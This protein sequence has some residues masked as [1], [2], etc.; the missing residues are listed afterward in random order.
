MHTTAQAS[1]IAKAIKMRDNW[2]GCSKEGI[3][4]GSRP[5][6]EGSS[7]VLST[8]R[9]KNP[10]KEALLQKRGFC[11]RRRLF[12]EKKTSCFKLKKKKKRK[13]KKKEADLIALSKIVSRKE[14]L[15]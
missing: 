6:P 7:K 8:G 14:I 9:T 2:L 12:Q 4:T 5:A 1:R 3:G 11:F 13:E 10:R 15:T